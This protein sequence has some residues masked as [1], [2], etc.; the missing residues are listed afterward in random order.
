MK[1]FEKF[2]RIG[3]MPHRSYYIPF[4]EKDTVR[5]KHGILDRTSSSRFTS[6]D[7]V[8]QIKQ[9]DHVEDFDVNEMLGASIPVPACVQMHGYDH[10]QY[11]N[12]RYPFPV[13]LP[14]LPYE[15]PC[16]HYRRTFNVRKQK[17]ERYYIN[18]EGVD[19]AFYIYINGEFKGYSQ[20]SH[21][22]SE[23]DVTDLVVNGENT[24]DVLVLKWCI[25]TYLECQDKFRFSGIFRN[26][27]MLT[28]PEGHITDYKIE[29]TYSGKD[30]ILTFINESVTDIKIVLEDNIVIVPAKMKVEIIV[31]NVKLWTAEEPNL[32]TLEL[33][34]MGEKIIESI[35]FRVVSIDGKIFKIN[36]EPVKLK[37]V[38]RHD[39]H[40]ETAAT[41]G[42]EDMAKDIHLMKELNVNAVRTSHYPNSPEFYMLCDKFGIYVMDEADLEMH[43]ACSR[44]GRYDIPLWEE[45]AE[46]DFFTPGITDRHTALVERDKNRPSVIIWSLGNESSFGKAFFKG[47]NYIKNRDKTR[48][49]HYEGLQNADP[50]Y[51]YTELVDM[52]SMMYPSFQTIK[53]KVLDN[54]AENRPFVMC[55][56]T[57]AMGNSCGDI[58]EYWNMIY[59]NEQMMG[60]FVWEWADHGIKTDE[61]FLYGGDFKEPEHD[62]NFCAD[63]LLT[64]DRKIKSNA[65]EM[66]AVYGGKTKSEICPVEVPAS[67]YKFSSAID[68]E[69]NEHT[70]EITSIKADG[71]EVLRTPIHFN[72]T[73]YTDNDRD[74]VPHWIGRCHLDA[75]KPQIF[76]CEKTN[77]SYK[78][79]GCL[80]ANCLMPAAEFELLYVV[81]GNVLTATI[82]YKLADYVERFPRFGIEF[83][84]DKAYGNF[85][86]AGFGPNESYVDKHIASE[87]GYYVSSA[88]ENY[89]YEYIRPQES[90]SHYACKY[91]AIKNLFKVTAEHPFSCSVNPFTTAQL[92]ET[93]HS[94]ELTENDFV[95]VC[96]DLAMRGVG[97]HSCGPD[98]PDEYEIP[99]KFKNTFTFTF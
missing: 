37:G 64:P 66:M 28:R 58:A 54:P 14:H 21:A 38:N 4:D 30:G 8:W 87:Y 49:V 72:I 22:T 15:N 27:Y 78:F 41:V 84:V 88:E 9:H 67:T 29:T 68:I 45:Y 89:D 48:P 35:G 39:F 80:A 1:E 99:K 23:F 26:V 77:N 40:C 76:S 50:K 19:S 61:G 96:I 56:Y 52:V 47:A 11:L 79:K 6:L 82:E 31:P 98:L 71:N 2:D 70:G 13:M 42:L 60:A 62:G 65:L 16:W 32:Y 24:I 44:D 10:I 51:Y 17:G 81:T 3:T 5:T 97:S 59:N 93:L 18:F 43:G 46:N 53:E 34:A 91:M 63:G 55:E 33:Y 25:S 95:N 92:R 12:I 7:G 36:G 90:G 20:I 86:Y 73:R 94:F 83:G 57:H 69:V 74:L 75:C 85:S